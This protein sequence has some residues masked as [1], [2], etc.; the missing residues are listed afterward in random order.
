[1]AIEEALIHIAEGLTRTNIASRMSLAVISL[2]KTLV[3]RA[4]LVIV[5]SNEAYELYMLR[6]MQV[7]L[8]MEYNYLEY[9]GIP[10]LASSCVKRDDIVIK[11][12][13]EHERCEIDRLRTLGNRYV[14]VSEPVLRTS[15]L[16]DD[17]TGDLSLSVLVGFVMDAILLSL[18]VIFT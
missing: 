5:L 16:Q 9:C 11:V 8:M 18:L 10:L 15:Y 12:A 1:M 3:E 4:D 17:D 2:P 13:A 7:S 6:V 14:V